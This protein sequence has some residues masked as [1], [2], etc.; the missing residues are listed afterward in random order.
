MT[1]LDL[2]LALQSVVDGDQDSLARKTLGL[3]LTP[4]T[5]ET[6]KHYS[7]TCCPNCG[8]P[9]SNPKSPYC[10]DLCK[11]EAAFVRQFRSSIQTGAIE[12]HERQA[13]LGQKL[14]HLLGGG[15]PRRIALIL[16]RALNKVLTRGCEICGA[17]A[18]TVDNIG[19]G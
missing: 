12:D 9:E 3:V 19:S 6:P 17:P 15:Y 8:I 13:A 10:G 16:P 2:R 4:T 1:T 14:W 5:R 11:E 18:T 7:P